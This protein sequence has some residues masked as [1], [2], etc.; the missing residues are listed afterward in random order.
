MT[1]TTNL[2]LKKPDADDFYNVDD[3]NDN[4]DA[5]DEAVAEKADAEHTHKISEITDF[6]ESF[7]ADGGNADTIDGKHAADF[8]SSANPT[9]SGVVSLTRSDTT[10]SNQ[11][12]AH[13]NTLHLRCSDPNAANKTY[14]DIIIST[15]GL[16][17][18]G[19]S[20]GTL[21]SKTNLNDGGNA[22]KLDGKHAS[23]FSQIIN[24]STSTDTKTAVGIPYKTTTYWCQAWTD[25]P[26]TLQ[27]GQGMIIAVNYKG[28]GTAGTD[29]IWCRQFYFSPRTSA[30][31]YQR[32][33]SGTSV[34]EWTNIADGGNAATANTAGTLATTSSN[35][36]LRNL[37]SGT[38]AANTTNCPSGAWYGQ[39][40]EV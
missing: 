28:S 4:F 6:P 25:Y 32:I 31:I 12:F 27:D 10:T 3:F 36:C 23:D 22:D 13:N 16:Y 26:A 24:L 37:S 33:I 11:I 38:A 40:E 34:G 35:I 20:N 9:I 19:Y 8:A 39:Y 30:K 2:H 14:Y 7:P 15:T 29:S 18:E 21:I 17:K 5:I 1:E